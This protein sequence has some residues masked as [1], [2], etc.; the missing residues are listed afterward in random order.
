ML[1]EFTVFIL[2]VSGVERVCSSVGA[3]W[4]HDTSTHYQFP[5]AVTLGVRWFLLLPVCVCRWYHEGLSRMAAE[6]MLKRIHYD[7]AF[8]VRHSVQDQ[9]VYAI[10]FRWAKWRVRSW[11]CSAASWIAKDAAQT[12][13]VNWLHTKILSSYPCRW[14]CGLWGMFKRKK[15]GGGEGGSKRKK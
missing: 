5:S 8:L 10:S 13:A 12:N 6:D 4:T 11:R 14:I 9:S 2:L 15:G 3:W 1:A 7:G